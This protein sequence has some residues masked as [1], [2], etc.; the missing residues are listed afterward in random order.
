[1][2]EGT[3]V[4]SSGIAELDGF[5]N[6]SIIREDPMSFC[7]HCE[8]QRFDRA[9]VLRALRATRKR[10][11][12]ADSACSADQAMAMAIEAVRALEIPHLERVDELVEGEVIH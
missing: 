4:F 11:P 6:N 1:V 7:D 9:Q 10:L 2:V 12:K 5:G 3:R 8:G